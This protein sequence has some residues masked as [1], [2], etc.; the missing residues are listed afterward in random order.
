M[1]A[2]VAGVRLHVANSEKAPHWVAGPK[3]RRLHLGFPGL[4]FPPRFTM[5][6]DSRQLSQMH[7]T[8]KIQDFAISTSM[9]WCTWS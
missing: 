6:Q 1:C 9:S 8:F 2:L 7:I 3:S 4:G 5:L